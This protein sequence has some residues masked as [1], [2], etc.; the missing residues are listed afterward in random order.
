M[1]LYPYL[2]LVL[3]VMPL[4][5]VRDNA[6]AFF[7]MSPADTALIYCRAL[8]DGNFENIFKYE[9][10]YQEQVRDIQVNSPKTLWQKK[11]QAYKEAQKKEDA[12]N[13]LDWQNKLRYTEI[14]VIEERKESDKIYTVFVKAE[15]HSYEKSRKPNNGQKGRVRISF[16][17]IKVI[18]ENYYEVV[19]VD[20]SDIELWDEIMRH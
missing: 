14:S 19:S 18:K 1:K 3:L 10:E 6:Q 8:Q 20:T 11:I 15:S 17:R 2:L 5:I 13:R 7:E 16:F 4:F 9:Y 12:A